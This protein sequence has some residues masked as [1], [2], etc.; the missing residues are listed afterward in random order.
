MP[1]LAEEQ[2]RAGEAE[3]SAWRAG[4]IDDVSDPYVAYQELCDYVL[5]RFRAVDPQMR[6]DSDFWSDVIIDVS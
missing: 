5:G 1:L 4:T 2:R 6:D 3:I